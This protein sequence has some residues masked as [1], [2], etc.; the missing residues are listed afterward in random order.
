[1]RPLA[2]PSLQ[3]VTLIATKDRLPHLLERSLPSVS[4]QERPPQALIIV[5]DGPTFTTELVRQ[6]TDLLFPIP[7]VILTNACSPGAAGAWNTGLHHLQSRDYDGY[8][9]ILDDDD[10]WD[11]DHIACNLNTAQQTGAHLVVSGLR[12]L[13]KGE[14][15]PRDL[16][17]RLT[18]DDFLRGN[19]GLQGSNTFVGAHALHHAGYFTDGL[20]SLNDRDLAV[21]LLRLPELQIAYTG[22]W[23]ANWHHGDAPD[24]LSTPRSTAKISGLQMFWEMHGSKMSPHTEAHY[25]DRAWRFFGVSRREIVEGLSR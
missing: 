25:F 19:P 7:V 8:V 15:R 17:M 12:H 9:A 13:V 23:T 1:M 4:R 6:I 5:N 24:T 16:P 20:L 14:I 3:C 11:A 2:D 10:S 18:A 21:R 22:K